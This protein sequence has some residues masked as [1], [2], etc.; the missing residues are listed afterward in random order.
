[1]KVKRI[2]KINPY[3]PTASMADIVF[4]LIIFF[5][6]TF[7]MDPDKES[8]LELPDSTER[9]EVPK[10]AAIISIDKNKIIRVS[11]G[12]EMTRQINQ[13][14]VLYFALNVIKKYPSKPIV[15]K[16]D[17]ELPF[18]I[19]DKVIDQLKQ[20][21]VGIIYLLTEQKIKKNRK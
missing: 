7:N 11:E 15:I 9:E 14:E 16:A 4:L 17:K 10:R 12:E 8:I 1:M 5:V 6:L 20:A 18:K 3:I 13:E 2:A 19:I 21:K